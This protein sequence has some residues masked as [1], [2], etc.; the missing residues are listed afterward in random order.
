MRQKNPP[1]VI[2]EDLVQIPEVMLSLV[3]GKEVQQSKKIPMN[4]PGRETTAGRK[5]EGCWGMRAGATPQ[6]L[7][8]KQ[9]FLMIVPSH[10]VRSR[11]RNCADKVI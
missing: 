10:Q 4:A 3:V 2:I 6:L 11:W 9:L 8:N 5:A 1:R 7:G